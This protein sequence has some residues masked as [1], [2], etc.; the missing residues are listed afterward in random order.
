LHLTT[1][2][3]RSGQERERLW[4]RWLANDPDLEAFA[5]RRSTETPVVVLEPRD[6]TA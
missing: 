1:I 4:Q 6:G 5:A 2:G 3:R